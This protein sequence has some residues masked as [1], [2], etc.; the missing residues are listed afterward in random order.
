MISG[1]N[2]WVRQLTAEIDVLLDREATTWA[3]QD[4]YKLG[5]E[6]EILKIST[7]VLHEDIKGPSK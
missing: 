2:A 1:N 5:R 7:V 4:C 3:C 6:I